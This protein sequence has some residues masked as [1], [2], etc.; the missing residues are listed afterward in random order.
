VRNYGY[1]VSSKV[2]IYYVAMSSVILRF[3]SEVVGGIYI[4]I[5]LI[6]VLSGNINLVCIPY[7]LD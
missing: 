5:M 4:L 2:S 3:V 7:S 6:L 1:T